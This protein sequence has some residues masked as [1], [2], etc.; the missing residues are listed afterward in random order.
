MKPSF[1]LVSS[2]LDSTSA[3]IYKSYYDQGISILSHSVSHPKMNDPLINEDTVDFELKSSKQNIEKYGINTSGFVTPYSLMHPKFLKLLEKYYTY[4]FTNNS[5]DKFD[6]TVNKHALSRYGIES[7][8]STSDH[9]ID[10]IKSR[11]DSAIK[12]GELLVFY[13]HALP[14]RYKDDLGNARVNSDDLRRI[15]SYLKGKTDNKECKVLTS[16]LAIS[17]YY[18]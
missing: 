11:I 15:L 12:N 16:D 2:K 3:I 8:I 5:K 17:A 14:S 9:S 6:K 1:A 4:S 10:K 13:G 7:N 18:K